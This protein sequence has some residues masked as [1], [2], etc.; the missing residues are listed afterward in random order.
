MNWSRVLLK[1]LGH[2]LVMPRIGSQCFSIAEI[3]LVKEIESSS[4]SESAQSPAEENVSGANFVS[5]E[6]IRRPAL[7]VRCA[8]NDFVRHIHDSSECH[9]QIR[10]ILSFI[11]SLT[12]FRAINPLVV[13][14][15]QVYRQRMASWHFTSNAALVVKSL[16]AT[17]LY[18]SSFL[19]LVLDLAFVAIYC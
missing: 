14:Y 15:T 3:P 9:V 16:A 11:P 8:S 7:R 4:C 1:D 12:S 17:N 13:F 18:L 10:E 2:T 6:L 19:L 5:T